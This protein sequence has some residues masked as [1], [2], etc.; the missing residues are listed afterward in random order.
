MTGGEGRTKCELLAGCIEVDAQRDLVSDV[1]C[2]Y[3]HC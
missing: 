2:G 3:R 1:R